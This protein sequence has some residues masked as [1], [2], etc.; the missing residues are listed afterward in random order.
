[1]NRSLAGALIALL[2]TAATASPAGA[3]EAL[4]SDAYVRFDQG[5]QKWSIGTESVELVL[6]LNGGSFAATSL[7]SK[8]DGREFFDASKRP[9]EFRALVDGRAYTGATGGWRLAG[10][11]TTRLSQGE[12]QLVV[13][14]ENDLLRVD[15]TYVV[16]PASTV[17]RQWVTYR[18]VGARSI[19]LRDPYLLAHSLGWVASET[20]TLHYMTG[21]GYFTGSQMLRSAP[22]APGYRRTFD[23]KTLTLSNAYAP[24]L[25][26]S[27][28]TDDVERPVEINGVYLDHGYAHPYGSGAYMPWFSVSDSRGGVFYGL[29][30]YGRWAGD[31]GQYFDARRYIGLRVAGFERALKPGESVVTPKAFVGLFTGDLDDMGNELKR[32]Q[33]AYLWDLTSDAYFARPRYL[34]EMRWEFGKRQIMWGGGTQDN[35]DYRMASLFRAIAVMR[36]VGA[37][38]LWQD[39]GWH[40]HLGDNDGPDFAAVKQ[41]LNKHGM[42]LAVWWPLYQVTEQSRVLREH[43]DWGTY[44]PPHGAWILDLSRKEVLDYVTS[45]LESKV[46]EWGDFQWRLDAIPVWPVEKNET[47]M[48]EQHHNLMSLMEGFRRRHPGSSIDV[49]ADGGNL[50]GFESL[51][52]SDVSQLTDGGLLHV[53]NYYS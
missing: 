38:V 11:N 26:M 46:R 16:H 22:L 37:D 8:K 24:S 53:S 20:P 30:Y 25:D 14:L 42:Q 49:C 43:R 21:G 2:L 41:Y 36:Q 48:L 32:W 44:D 35:W 50:M 52:L 29:D 23:S 10:Q 40:N 13:S 34:A 39:A 1:M 18:N 33:Y 15:K 19:R 3:Q 27:D 5:A 4:S 47:V 28:T 17:I 9:E 51:R 31:V 12:L 7:R 45:E 6:R